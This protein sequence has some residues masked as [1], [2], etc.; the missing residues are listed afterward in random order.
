M[1]EYE[2]TDCAKPVF[3]RSPFIEYQKEVPYGSYVQRLANDEKREMT[4]GSFRSDSSDYRGENIE[5]VNSSFKKL[6]LYVC[7]SKSL[8][9]S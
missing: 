7:I 1:I 9:P 6:S 4:V 2:Q 3:I 8:S 5:K